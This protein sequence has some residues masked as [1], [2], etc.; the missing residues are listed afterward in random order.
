MS[1]LILSNITNLAGNGPVTIENGL[2]VGAGA[3]VNGDVTIAGVVTATAFSGDG[4]GLTSLPVASVSTI[5]ANKFLHSFDE[6]YSPRG[7]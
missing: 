6:F 1:K 5:V 7:S 4:S 3:T 2:Q